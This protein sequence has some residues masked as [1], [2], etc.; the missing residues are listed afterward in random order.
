MI[1]KAAETMIKGFELLRLKTYDD[2]F[3]VPTIGWG[4]TGPDAVPGKEITV[5]AA[6]VLFEAD[7]SVAVAAVQ[8]LVKVKLNANELGALVCLFFNVGETKLA[9][10]TLVRLLN[11]DLR[12]AASKQFALWD[13]AGEREVQGLL[14]RRYT[15]AALFLTPC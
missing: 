6:E 14:R 7:V 13:H 11:S 4:H 10:S 8:K 3:K 12:L 2:G 5:E 15:E 1:S 9:N